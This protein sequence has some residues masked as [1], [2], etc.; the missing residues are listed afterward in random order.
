LQQ[1]RPRRFIHPLQRSAPGGVS[2]PEPAVCFS[3][4]AFARAL[5]GGQGFPSFLRN[6][7]RPARRASAG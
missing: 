4:R 6:H 5:S 7:F 3:G 2:D 1:V